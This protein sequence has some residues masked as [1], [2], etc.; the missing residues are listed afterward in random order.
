M[1]E[2]VSTDWLSK[3]LTDNDLILL[4][5]SLQTTAEG[6]KSEYDH[7]TIPGA[8]YFDLKENFTDRNSKLP[9]TLPS[10]G[11]F[12]VECQKLG[13]NKTSRLIVFDNLGTYSSPRVWWMFKVMGH[14]NVSVLNGGLPE[15]IKKGLPTIKRNVQIFGLGNFKADLNVKL[16]KNYQEIVD[17]VGAKLFYV[18]DARSKG[19]FDGTEKEPRKGL[20]SGHIPNSINIPYTEVLCNGKYKAKSDLKKIF[21]SVC[22][23]ESNII[24]SCGSGLTACIVM[25]ASEVAYKKSK[26]VYDGSWTE[27]AENQNL[28]ENV[29]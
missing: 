16:V 29:S 11:Q 21:K 14:D 18:I 9:N 10:E 23:D 28:K 25:L 20:K 15:W 12:E 2:L 5:A 17:N 27:W 26:C 8:R 4:D 19:R 3:H 22:P 24:F 6:K 1:T 7:D 13:I